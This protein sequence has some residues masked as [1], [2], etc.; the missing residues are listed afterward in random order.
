MKLLIKLAIAAFIA[1]AAWRLGMGYI[2]HYKFEDSVHEV[3][4][5]RDESEADLRQ[6]V[7]EI[8]AQ[9]EVPL[10][11][12]AFTV[13]RQDRRVYVEGSYVKPILLLPGFERPWTF[14]LDIEAY[15]ID[16]PAPRTR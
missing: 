13:R 7:L 3:M 4:L 1:N 14:T 11:D 15:V 8:A 10:T 6:R 9:Q 5:G 16:L 2:S 12:E